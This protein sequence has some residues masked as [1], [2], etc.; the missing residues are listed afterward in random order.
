MA[1]V[2]FFSIRYI[3]LISIVTQHL[4]TKSDVREKQYDVAIK[5]YNKK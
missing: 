2:R 3:S 5:I 4:N 1:I